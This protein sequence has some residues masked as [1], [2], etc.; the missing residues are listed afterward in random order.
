MASRSE[1]LRRRSSTFKV[2]VGPGIL[3]PTIKWYTW[4]NNL[5]INF[6]YSQA[7]YGSETFASIL[8]LGCR[9]YNDK[10]TKRTKI[11]TIPIKNCALDKRTS[12]ILPCITS[13]RFDKNVSA[14]SLW[15]IHE[16][17]AK[18]TKTV[19]SED[20]RFIFD[21]IDGKI[22]HIDIPGAFEALDWNK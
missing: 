22:V 8:P 13:F 7:D 18:E 15:L 9:T 14:L 11:L 19:A 10:A 5:V 4:Q 17:D 3:G 21:T 1:P 2:S 6:C 20:V 16:K 12:E